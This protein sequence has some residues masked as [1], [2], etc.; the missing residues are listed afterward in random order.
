MKIGSSR[1]LR[2]SVLFCI[3]VPGL[4]LAA[5]APC[6]AEQ[7]IG[8]PPA[9]IQAFPPGETLTY[10]VSWSRMISAGT[11]TMTVERSKL[12]DEREVL[13]FVVQGRTQGLVDKVFPVSD[14]VQS[15]FDPQLMQSLSYN[16]RESYG[17][18]KRLRV[19]EFDHA[20]RTAVCRLNED[21]P[22][23]LTVPDPVQ[24]GLSLLYFL[25]SMEDLVIGR[26]MDIDVVDSGKNWT[27][28]VSILAREKVATAAGKFAAI[29]IKTA[30]KDK[31]V[32]TTKGEVFLWLTDDDRKIPVLMK[33]TLKVGSFVFELSEIK[34]G[35]HRSM[36]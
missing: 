36:Q 8:S 14:S 26:R 3:L 13:R 24:D 33:S 1:F 27:I 23:T 16:L 10:D 7:T 25:R 2:T 15:V 4:L 12:P 17:K 35:T 21:P 31:G 5:A 29:K 28:E 32:V 20:K 6:A 11:V 9:G 30:P 22:E 19:T 18:K 34:P